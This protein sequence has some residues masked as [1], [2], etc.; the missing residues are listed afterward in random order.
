MWNDYLDSQSSV[1]VCWAEKGLCICRDCS[2]ENELSRDLKKKQ[3]K[4]R[5]KQ[6]Y[7]LMVLI[8]ELGQ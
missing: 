8:L 2:N 3:R 4:Y 6:K 7:L 5:G 1:S